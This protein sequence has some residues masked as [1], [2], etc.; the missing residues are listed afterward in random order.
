MWH[1]Q[2]NLIQVVLESKGMRST[3][4][5]RNRKMPAIT[6]ESLMTLEA[7]SRVRTEF[8]ANVMAHKKNRTVHLGD[9][10]GRASCRERVYGTV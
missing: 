7:Y 5:K 3:V 10:I 4:A 9:Q 2:S 1:W 6:P 8:R